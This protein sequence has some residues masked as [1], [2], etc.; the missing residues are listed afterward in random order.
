MRIAAALVL[1]PVAAFA[2]AATPHVQVTVNEGAR[3][4]D[5]TIAGKPFTSYIW[6]TT[7]KKPTLY[8]LRTAKGTV[9]TRGFPLEPRKG[10][11]VDHPHHVGLW[12][13]YGDVNGLDFWNN[14]DAIPA[15]QAPKMG[16]ILHRRVVEAKSGADQGE[17]AVEMDWVGP[18]KKPLLHEQTR[19]IFRGTGETRTIDR[20]TTLTA[21]DQRVIFHDIKEG[22]LGMRVARGLE[23]PADKPEVFTDA[24][25]K[26][27]AVPVLD[28]TGVTGQYI[29]SEGLKGDAVWGTRGKW[30]MLARGGGCGAGHDRDPRQPVESRLSDLLACARLRAVRRQSARRQG[31]H[32]RQA[33]AEPDRRARQIR[34]VQV[35]D[36]DSERCRDPGHDRAAVQ[37]LRGSRLVV[38][39]STSSDIRELEDK[40][41]RLARAA[42]DGGVQGVLLATHHNIAWLTGGRSN[43]VDSSREAG[44]SRLLVTA[45][46]RRLVLANA[47]EMPR[48][49]EEVL[50]GLE[51][52]PVEYP[53]TND[54]DPAFAVATARGLIGASA[55][56]GA[57][58]AAA[59]NGDVR[60]RRRANAGAADRRGD[61]SLPRARTRHRPGGRRRVPAAVAR[62]RRARDRAGARRRRSATCRP[63]ASCCSSDRTSAS[64]AI[65]ILFQPPR[66]GSTS[67]W[68]RCA[69]NATA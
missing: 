63:G 64:A 60:E 67:S 54:Q 40:V 65:G 69:P 32:E 59:R 10:E 66:P 16:T 19:F 21:L 4:V 58:C 57:D 43:R 41:D 47:I 28:N 50:A 23:Q 36:S 56:I 26:A 52:E 9:V 31:F 22:F 55:T 44:T 7:L 51:F 34:V 25:G 30:T 2:A 12:L 37:G 61:R 39:K 5:V 11:R 6:P 27:T 18:D 3:R 46:G 35:S 29:S 48:M 15:E 53:W 13:N 1:L 8:P 24:S 14:S 38:I 62:R 45:D 49:L 33:G 42:Q 68:S 17:L 20:L